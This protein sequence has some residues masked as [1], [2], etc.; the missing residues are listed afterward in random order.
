MTRWLGSLKSKFP[1]PAPPPLREP[2]PPKTAV[3]DQVLIG[4]YT[5][6][7]NLY[8]SRKF[9][10]ALSLYK[11]LADLAPSD[12]HIPHL[13]GMLYWWGA[14]MPRDV[15]Q[16]E[17][18]LERAASGGDNYACLSLSK[19]YRDTGRLDQSLQWLETLATKSYPPALFALGHGWEFGYW[20]AIDRVRAL[21]YY[22]RAAARGYAQANWRIGAMLLAGRRGAW[23]IPLGLFK[24]VSAFVRVSI[25][26]YRDPYDERVIW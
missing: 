25:L 21:V 2:Q 4:L 18:W 13:I 5:D 7:G 16:A 1:F 20:G 26:L 8:R 24:Y 11:R 9:G 17:Q 10:K 22:E 19:V 3:T 23:R 14:E 12:P 15:P 6:A